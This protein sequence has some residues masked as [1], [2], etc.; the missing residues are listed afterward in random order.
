MAV[1]FLEA[2]P[3]GMQKFEGTEP[4]SCSFWQLAARGLTFYPVPGKHFNCAVGAYTHGIALSRT[5][6][7]DDV[8]SRRCEAGKKFSKL[9]L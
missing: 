4:S 5:N 6:A 1:A 3:A 9:I 7:R 2:E 8:R